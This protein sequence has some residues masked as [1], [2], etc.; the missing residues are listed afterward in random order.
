MATGA[1]KR[2]GTDAAPYLLTTAR[3]GEQQ[4]VEVK[5][6]AGY[7][8]NDDYPVSFEPEGAAR[9]QLKDA[10]KST[11]CEG[12]AAHH[13]S[14]AVSVPNAAGTLAFSV[15]SADQC[16]IEKVKLAAAAK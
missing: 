2:E 8:I 9:L 13:C 5:T 6:A 14:A 16:L 1:C 10:V 4:R 7:H 11:A 12:D 3:D 15:C